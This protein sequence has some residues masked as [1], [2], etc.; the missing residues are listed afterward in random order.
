VGQL[1]VNRRTRHH[2]ERL[3]VAQATIA[4]AEARVEALA[5]REPE[6]D[7][8]KQRM[9]GF[10][11]IVQDV[12]ANADALQRKQATLSALEERLDGLEATAKRTQWQFEGLADQRKD[13][14][15][16]KEEIHAVHAT[17]EQAATLRDRLRADNQ[18][19]E[20][21]LEKAGSLWLARP[22]SEPRS[23]PAAGV[24][25]AEASVA[26]LRDC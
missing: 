16:L 3:S 7:H 6:L 12:S 15:T 23:T 14:E 13:L 5:A 4:G 24:A 11:A 21:F 10:A 26:N 25:R 8:L 9:D 17:Y 1:A 20:Q 22:R 18:Q 19:V 2:P